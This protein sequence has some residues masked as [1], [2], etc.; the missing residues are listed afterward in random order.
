MI[1]LFLQKAIRFRGI[2]FALNK[3][4]LFCLQIY[5]LKHLG[6]PTNKN[7]TTNIT[8]VTLWPGFRFKPQAC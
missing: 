8:A 1:F 7:E 6:T 4:H 5:P 3:F 2:N